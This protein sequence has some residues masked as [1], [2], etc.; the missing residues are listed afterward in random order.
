MYLSQIPQFLKGP[1]TGLL[2]W[3]S[4][5]KTGLISPTLRWPRIHLHTYERRGAPGKEPR[6]LCCLVSDTKMGVCLYVHGCLASPVLPV[7]RARVY[8]GLHGN[9]AACQGRTKPRTKHLIQWDKEG[10]QLCVLIVTLSSSR[11]FTVEWRN[12]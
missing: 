10:K 2:H 5:W 1:V 7:G 6:Y 3:V 8:P 11:I 12:S 9:T 4:R